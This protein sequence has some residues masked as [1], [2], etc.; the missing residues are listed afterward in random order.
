MARSQM[1]PELKFRPLFLFALC[2]EW[3]VLC[4]CA[5]LSTFS[6]CGSLLKLKKREEG[7]GG[8]TTLTV[9][10]GVFF[11]LF[12]FALLVPGIVGGGGIVVLFGQITKIFT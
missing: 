8:H 11:F 5:V 7:E 4:S 2:V 9:P 12:F 6:N 3:E 10:C 1:S